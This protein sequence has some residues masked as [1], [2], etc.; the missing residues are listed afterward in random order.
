MTP[1]CGAGLGIGISCLSWYLALEAA[2][3]QES[4]T[5]DAF[6]WPFGI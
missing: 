1:L 4:T 5:H 3:K 6:F 2:T